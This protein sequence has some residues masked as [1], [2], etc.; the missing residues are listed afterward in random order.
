MTS[1]L[2]GTGDEISEQVR[3]R[4]LS[5]RDVDGA[6]GMCTGP[7]R[8]RL[9]LTTAEQRAVQG[10]LQILRGCCLPDGAMT[11]ANLGTASSI[12]VWIPPYF[13]AH[14]ACALLAS[15]NTTDRELVRKWLEW[16]ALRQ[17]PGGW[18]NDWTGTR[19]SYSNTGKCDAHDSVVS[20]YLLVLRKYQV[21]GGIVSTRMRTAAERA[22]A[23]LETCVD[24][25][26]GLTWAKPSY[27]VAFLMDNTESYAG[28]ASGAAFFKAVGDKNRGELCARRQAKLRVE[29]PKYWNSSARLYNWAKHPN[30]TVNGGLNALYPEGLANIFGCSFV[31]NQPAAFSQVT[32]KFTPETVPHGAGPER[33]A[34]AAA[35]VGGAVSTTWRN[36]ATT[37]AQ[38]FTN[39]NVYSFRP[40]LYVLLAYE[41][42]DWMPSVASAVQP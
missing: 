37:T 32:A 19:A 16:M 28:Y 39:V 34:M 10:N 9:A 2:K 6:G 25:A 7:E 14:N 23:C 36:R 17:E 29:L 38:G 20:F 3:G 41:G 13:S 21:A 26:T 30:G 1:H 33:F 18:W 42:A 5:N 40:A 15:G 4:G 11:M 35:R 27:R 24:P 31:V 8:G 22:L 12:P